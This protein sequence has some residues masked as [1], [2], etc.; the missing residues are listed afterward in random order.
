MW[1]PLAVALSPRFTVIAPDLPGI[2]NSSIPAS[3]S[4]MCERGET[5]ARRGADAL[6]YRKV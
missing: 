1:K 3:G 5:R 6:G 4:D 2:G